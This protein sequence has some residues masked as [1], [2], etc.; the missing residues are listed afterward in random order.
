MNLLENKSAIITGA[1]SGIG[2]AAARLFASHG[3]RLVLVAR[4]AEPLGE[5]CSELG[6][7][8][9]SVVGDVTQPETHDRAVALAK[10]NFGSLDIA[11][12]NAGTLGTLA[13][14]AELTLEDWEHTLRTN[15]TACFLA[16]SAQ[17]P[18]MLEHGGGSLVFTGSFVGV[19]AAMPNMGAYGTTKAGLTGLVKSITADYAH[20]GIRANTLL[21]GAVDTPM[22]GSEENKDW[23][24]TLHPVRRIAFP[25]EIAQ[26][27]LFL[28]SDMASF[29]N[30]SN[31]WADGGNS[32]TKVQAS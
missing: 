1:S 30:G 22:A 8:A 23:A 24:A 21:P 9:L 19:S 11:F 26:A 4:S 18:A 13:P 3:A 10:E 12:N 20:L 15:L 28:A 2:L 6:D 7:S 29:V 25:E 31:L 14:L 17:L 16:A 27:A 32:A 5:L